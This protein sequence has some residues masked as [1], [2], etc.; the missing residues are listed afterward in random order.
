MWVID[1]PGRGPYKPFTVSTLVILLPF[2]I[3]SGIVS[4]NSQKAS[5][6]NLVQLRQYVSL[7]GK[8]VLSESP[9]YQ[10][11]SPHPLSLTS[12]LSPLSTNN[13]LLPNQSAIRP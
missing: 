2:T 6:A 13:P 9:A 3:T 11:V 5:P 4:L 10:Q 12:S 7:T 8:I 1:D